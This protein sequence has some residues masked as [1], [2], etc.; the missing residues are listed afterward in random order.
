VRIE[1][2]ISFLEKKEEN[3][4]YRSFGIRATGRQHSETGEIDTAT[5]KFVE[6]IDYNPKYDE[7]YLQT[8]RTRAKN[9]W[10]GIDTENWLRDLRGGYDS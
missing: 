3:L 7:I 4:L 1:T 10:K 2:P 8:L 9:T 6:L 5:I